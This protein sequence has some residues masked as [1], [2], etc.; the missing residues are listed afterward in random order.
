MKQSPELSPKEKSKLVDVAR[1]AYS[2]SDL[3]QSQ[4]WSDFSTELRRQ[5]DQ[6][7][8]R[9]IITPLKP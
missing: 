2:Q 7:P 3:E 4:F 5:L 1:A 8:K 6:R 9:S